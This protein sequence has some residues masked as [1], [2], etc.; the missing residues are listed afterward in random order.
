MDELTWTPRDRL[1]ARSLSIDHFGG[2]ATAT[3]R[4]DVGEVVQLQL[5]HQFECHFRM[6]AGIR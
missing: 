4:V 1:T 2:P 6:R 3:T 5:L